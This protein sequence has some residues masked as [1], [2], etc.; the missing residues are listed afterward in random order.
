MKKKL[1]LLALIP[2]A[3]LV[4]W[5]YMRKHEPPRVPFAAATRETLTSTL[6]TN[7]KVEPMEWQAIRAETAGLVDRLTVQDGQQVAKGAPVA[8]LTE[9]GLQAEVQAAEARVAEARANLAT[10]Q[11]GGRAS[12][13]AE[14]E[15]GLARARFDLQESQRELAS[16]RRLQEKGAATLAEVE[17]ARGKTRQA[18]LQIEALQKRRAALVG[19]PDVTVAQARLQDAEAA[20]ALA[21]VKVAQ[22]VVRAPIG[23]TV[24]GA[25]VRQGAFVETGTLLANVGRFDRLRVR[26]YVDEPELGRVAEGQPVAI[27]WDALPGKTWNGTVEKK[28]ASIEA[29]G[30]RQVG[31][32]L[33]SIENPGRELIPGT[34]VNAEIRTA[35]VPDAVVIP[36]ECL[37]RDERGSFVFVLRD[38]TVRRQSVRTGVSSITRLQVLDGVKAGD[39]V[40]LPTDLPLKDGMAVTPA[41]Q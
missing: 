40:A 8:Y 28:P 21:R 14:I 41:Q 38:N 11:G 4:W 9:P 3:A 20:L 31:E 2:L 1:F 25:A 24:Y 35:V 26:V 18:E 13:I 27:T 29:L 30:T 36:K 34:N 19:K 32:V 17:S 12:E 23:G 6:P 39:A 5:A 10:L 33:C 16:L 37:R 22:A 15:N 7:G